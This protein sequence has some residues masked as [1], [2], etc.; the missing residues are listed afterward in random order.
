MAG[1]EIFRRDG[2]CGTCHMR[3]GQGLP[4]SGFP[5]LV[6]TDWV[7]GDKERLVKL[8]LDGLT[9][10]IEVN[11]VMYLGQVPMTPFR[12]LLTDEEIADVL[13]YVRNAFGNSASQVEAEEVAAIRA[14]T[15]DRQGILHGP[16]LDSRIAKTC[17]Y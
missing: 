14:A 17:R 2:Y 1:R 9:G 12:N 15:A 10:P 6:G 16:R 5:P 7:V 8:T 11:D 4:A 3:D 13:T